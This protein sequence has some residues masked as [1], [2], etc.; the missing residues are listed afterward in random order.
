MKAI[1]FPGQGAQFKGM[2]QDLFPLYPDQ[3]A[4]A[5]EVLGYCI[6]TLCLEDPDELLGITRYT[7]PALYVVNALRYFA[8]RDGGKPAAA[9]AAGHS[10]GECNALLAAG[11]FD[12]ET[13][14][15][16]VQKR[17]QLMSSVGGGSMLVVMGI[18]IDALRTLIDEL[19]LQSIDLA[20]FNSPRQTVVAGP[21]ADVA[22]L[23]RSCDARGIDCLP[24]AVSCPFHSRYMRAQQPAFEE[25]LRG[26]TL[27]E[28]AIPVISN[29]TAQPYRPGELVSTLAAQIASPVNWIGCVQSLMALGA[30]EFIELGPKLAIAR[31]TPLL[32]MVNEI[33]KAAVNDA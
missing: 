16:M 22:Q 12:F 32:R 23:E 17:G 13:G 25:F 27:R 10:L 1:L 15:R 31:P 7:Q 9:F 6:R 18:S 19:Q 14:L 21:L 4:L 5:S 11:C 8:W 26:L 24:V 30:D 33:R 2:G 28:P 3:T 29:V 20:N